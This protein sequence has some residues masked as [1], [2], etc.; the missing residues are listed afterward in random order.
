MF[1]W[2]LNK[3]LNHRDILHDGLNNVGSPV[4]E[5][6][7]DENPIEYLSPK[8]FENADRWWEVSLNGTLL[9][10]DNKQELKKMFKNWREYKFIRRRTKFYID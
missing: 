9:N 1:R 3:F 2:S 5:L 6:R 7:L 8:V 10:D 4:G